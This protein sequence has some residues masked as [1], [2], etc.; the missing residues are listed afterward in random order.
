MQQPRS[1]FGG[2]PGRLGRGFPGEEEWSGAGAGQ[3]GSSSE[4]GGSEDAVPITVTH[5]GP[6]QARPRP[7][8]GQGQASPRLERA[9]SE[10]PNKFKQRLNL[11]NPLYSTIPENSEQAGPAARPAPARPEPRPTTT[12][13]KQSS[14]APS[15]PGGAPS[16][17]PPP[18]QPGVRH[19]PIFVEG[20]QEP[21]LAGDPGRAGPGRSAEQGSTKEFPKP[22]DYYPP[23]VQRIK[24]REDDRWVFC[25]VCIY[26]E[27]L[28]VKLY[29]FFP[30]R[31]G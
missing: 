8:P 4:S 3:E 5:L 31:K 9:S 11:S 17:E 23:G 1:S 12:G 26:S 25:V 24:S 28:R 16:P 21:L 14:S 30:E 15:V 10:P 20:R 2:F 27:L 13:L 19:I 18:R 29:Y 22:S 7:D 6:G